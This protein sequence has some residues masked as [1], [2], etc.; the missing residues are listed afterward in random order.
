ML[1]AAAESNSTVSS[2]TMRP[3][4]GVIRPAIILTTDVLPAPDGP[5][6][7][8]TPPCASNC[9]ARENSP[10][11][12]STSTD[13]ISLSVE[14]RAGAARQPFGCDERGQRNDDG[15]DHEPSGCAFAA[16]YLHEGV[17]CRGDGLCLAGD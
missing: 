14:T 16:R 10:S 6:K 8:V 12:F 5:N 3:R 2:S 1:I 15:D 17:D 7:A 9:A 11:F 13:N 4:S